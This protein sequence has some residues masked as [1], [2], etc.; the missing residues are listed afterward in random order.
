MKMPVKTTLLAAIVCFTVSVSCWGQDTTSNKN[1]M[2]AL[3][4]KLRSAD[5]S[6]RAE[7]FEQVRSNPANLKSPEVRT[8]LLDL[9][10]RESH[11]L[12]AQLLE[13]QKK[14]YPDEGDNEPFAEYFSELLGAVDSFADWNDPRQACI[15]VNANTSDDSDLVAKI[16]DHAKVALPCLLKRSES[17]ISA[18]RAVSAPVLVQVL[19]KSKDTLDPKTI[20]AAKRIILGALQD[21]DEGV[22]AFTV[23]ALARYGAEDMV[24]ALRKVAESDPSPIVDGQS[25][26]SMALEAIAAI[27]KRTSRPLEHEAHSQR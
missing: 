18:N 26:R 16:A 1:S 3:L 4:A 25:I 22:R 5:Q 10:D 9:L 21:S 24:P 12:D 17:G 14:G 23:Y 20:Q 2:A 6:A 7:A 27:Q 15:L 11:E 13:A 19:A 8:A